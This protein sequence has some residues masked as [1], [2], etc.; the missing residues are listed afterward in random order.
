MVASLRFRRR[1]ISPAIRSQLIVPSTVGL[2]LVA[3][4][5]WQTQS[6]C[7]IR[8]RP[9]SVQIGRAFWGQL[10]GRSNRRLRR[11]R[12][13]RSGCSETRRTAG[14]REKTTECVLRCSR[15]ITGR[16]FCGEQEKRAAVQGP[17]PRR[18][19]LPSL[20]TAGFLSG[21]RRTRVVTRVLS[22]KQRA[23]GLPT[24]C[25]LAKA[26]AANGSAIYD[27]V[28]TVDE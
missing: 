17:Q 21:Q 9:S 26:A 1:R 8:E 14:R 25:D 23:H 28:G 3:Q 20:A 2:R 22:F 27:D 18:S 15:G 13:A 4:L 12:R 24:G 5:Q 19:S 10:L 16:H 7:V 11:S 6:Q